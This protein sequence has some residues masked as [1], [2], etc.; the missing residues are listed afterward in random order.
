MQQIYRGHQLL[1]LHAMGH[2]T[3]FSKH[4]GYADFK[5]RKEDIASGPMTKPVIRLIYVTTL[6]DMKYICVT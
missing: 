2:D 6:Q 5:V 4:V 3:H 1:I